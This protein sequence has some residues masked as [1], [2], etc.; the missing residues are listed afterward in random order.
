L[1]PMNPS[2]LYPLNESDMLFRLNNTYD[3]RDEKYPDFEY[4]LLWRNGTITTIAEYQMYS[5]LHNKRF[6]TQVS[7]RGK[8]LCTVTGN[9][10]ALMY[11]YTDK[12]FREAQH[13]YSI[14]VVLLDDY[15]E[16]ILEHTYDPVPIPESLISYYKDHPPV[17]IGNFLGS[18]GLEAIRKAFEE[19]REIIFK[20]IEED[21]YMPPVQQLLSD[22]NHIFAFTH[23]M[24]E[25]G[26]VLV[27]IFDINELTYECSAWFPVLMDVIKNGYAYR[28]NKPADEFPVIE[29]Y[30]IDPAV[31]GK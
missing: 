9:K 28:I 11:G 31:Y 26:A 8:L 18:E 3:E 30:R 4:V 14:H 19:S 23:T 7:F 6:N 17:P 20:M 21:K 24:N 5:M 2:I 12:S 16:T 29:K 27:D 25:Q 22:R 13:F 15:Q 1:R 10:L